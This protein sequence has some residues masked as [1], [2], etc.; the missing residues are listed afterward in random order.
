[1]A[2]TLI[3]G[4]SKRAEPPWWNPEKGHHQRVGSLLPD[5]LVEAAAGEDVQAMGDI[6]GAAS[7]PQDGRLHPDEG[8]RRTHLH[9]DSE[10]NV[11]TEMYLVWTKEGHN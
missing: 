3:Q 9:R 6:G 10:G 4:D 5:P 8:C 2:D 1:M 11:Y 7:H